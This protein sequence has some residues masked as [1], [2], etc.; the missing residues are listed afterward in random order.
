MSAS[1]SAAN[2]PLPGAPAPAARRYCVFLSYSH[3]D[4]KWARWLMRR[5]ESYAVPKRFFGRTAP[6]GVVGRRIAPV[7]R[8]R[9]EL[10]TTSDLGETIRA[11]LRDS[12]TLVVI[13]SPASARSRWVQEEIT[14]FKRLHGEHGVFAFIVSGEPKSAGA[15]DDCFSPALRAGIGA[16]GSLSNVPAEHV[17]ADA[18]AEGDGPSLAFVR[19]VAGL[20]GVGFDE[21]RRREL[22]RRNRRL[23]FIAAASVAGMALTLGLSV[24]AWQARNDAQRRQDQ[25]EDVLAFML[26]DFRGELK[27]LGRLDLLDQ[28]GNKAM[29]YFDS[30]D[31]RDLTDTALARQAKALTQIGEVRIEQ[32]EARYADAVRA[33]LTAYRRTVTLAERHPTNADMLFERAQAEFW[34]GFVHRKRRDLRQAAEWL[35]RYRDSAL[36]L[37]KLEG[38]VLRARRE[39][40]SGHRNLAVLALDTGN[41]AAARE[42]FLSALALNREL[43]AE[44]PTDTE[45]AFRFADTVSWLASTAEQAG[46]LKEAE[47]RFA[48]QVSLLEGLVRVDPK[49]AHWRYKLAD[50]RSFQTTI[51]VITGQVARAREQLAQA[52]TSLDGLLAND[53]NNRRWQ[54]LARTIELQSFAQEPERWAVRGSI[55]T[56]E[57]ARREI[58][59]LA[60]AEPNDHSLVKLLGRAWRMESAVRHA[61]GDPQSAAASAQAVARAEALIRGEPKDDEIGASAQA[62]LIAAKIAA[63]QRD[64]P[65]ARGHCQRALEI[66]T[67]RMKDSRDWRLLDP[68]ARAL[69]LLGRPEESRALIERLERS[70]YQ[71]L[72][73]WPAGALPL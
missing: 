60:A 53:R 1:P 31:S 34:I 65:T 56:I 44:N 52:R 68:A 55:E 23:T 7:F 73:P 51:L 54:Q 43:V 24:A 59:K 36:A 14:A 16:D 4:T 37:L 58:E 71:P 48:Q 38:P 49:T 3:S 20:L 19:L 8:D 9:D 21:L 17:A 22:Q 61:Q 15:S 32:K 25:A 27:K 64:A 45:Q 33:F 26:G 62:Y 30:L 29:A 11:A 12:A 6:V 40:I 10:P 72:E 57:A 35:T 42:G 39:V 18:R 5:L 41:L 13:C 28:V 46:D 67:P 2:P 70:G 69:A 47:A 66:V 63:S 50:A